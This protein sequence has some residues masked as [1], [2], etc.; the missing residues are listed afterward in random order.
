MQSL[1]RKILW[2]LWF[3]PNLSVGAFFV[4]IIIGLLILLA[5]RPELVQ[6]V[7]P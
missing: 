3:Y 2:A 4:G 5:R 7:I 6:V 1:F